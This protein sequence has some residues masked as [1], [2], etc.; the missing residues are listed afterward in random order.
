MI[1]AE[2]KKKHNKGIILITPKLAALKYVAL[3]SFVT[4]KAT[5]LVSLLT[6]GSLFY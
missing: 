2:M 3:T 1:K 5:L 4:P 6:W